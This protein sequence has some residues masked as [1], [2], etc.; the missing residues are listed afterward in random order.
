MVQLAKISF[1]SVGKMWNEC[2]S[3]EQINT[4]TGKSCRGHW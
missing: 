4:K 3:D 1:F 2:C